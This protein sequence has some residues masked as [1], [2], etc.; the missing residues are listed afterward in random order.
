M[1]FRFRHWQY[2]SKEAKNTIRSVIV[3]KRRNPKENKDIIQQ[4][5]ILTFKK[6][7]NPPNPLQPNRITIPKKSQIQ[8]PKLRIRIQDEIQPSRQK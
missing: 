1:D 2:I 4:F 8:N 3:K 5:N 6:A 7:L